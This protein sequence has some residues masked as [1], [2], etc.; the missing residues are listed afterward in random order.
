M[1]C[2]IKTKFAPVGSSLKSTQIHFKTTSFDMKGQ[3]SS[4]TVTIN[5]KWASSLITAALDILSSQFM[6]N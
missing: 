2:C 5:L 4:E 1:Q 6:V 3:I